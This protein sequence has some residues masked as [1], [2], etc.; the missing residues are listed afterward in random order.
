MAM[1]KVEKIITSEYYD[2]EDVHNFNTFVN[3]LPCPNLYEGDVR[4]T[5]F[6]G[7]LHCRMPHEKL[8]D[9]VP[10]T[11]NYLRIKKAELE[12][13]TAQNTLKKLNYNVEVV[14]DESYLDTEYSMVRK[15]TFQ[16][17]EMERGYDGEEDYEVTVT[18]IFYTCGF[19]SLDLCIPKADLILPYLRGQKY[20]AKIDL[21]EQYISSYKNLLKEK[22]MY[23]F[24][25]LHNV[26]PKTF[27][28]IFDIR[29][30]TYWSS[31]FTSFEYLTY[32]DSDKKIY[33]KDVN[34][35]IESYEIDKNLTFVKDD[36][37]VKYERY[38]GYYYDFL[39][40]VNYKRI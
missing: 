30:I 32:K 37:Y 34:S 28:Q 26:Q 13:Q 36:K 27:K 20:G 8:S 35:L 40:D 21:I 25:D 22:Q 10:D 16:T 1:N 9:Y 33:P 3:S 39:Q 31:A 17:I 4:L 14:V 24:C 38:C 6:L 23:E 18:W 12:Y 15:H 29:L 7:L 11:E 2:L 19:H 5:A